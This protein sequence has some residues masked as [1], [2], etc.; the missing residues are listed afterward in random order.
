MMKMVNKVYT[1]DEVLLR[2]YF[3][4]WNDVRVSAE[5]AGR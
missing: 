3:L 4:G 1:V 5:R 2:Q